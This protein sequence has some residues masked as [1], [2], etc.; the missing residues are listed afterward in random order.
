MFL[1]LTRTACD[2]TVKY[3]SFSDTRKFSIEFNA[4]KKHRFVKVAESFFVPYAEFFIFA[5]FKS[6]LSL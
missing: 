3:N 4:R 1:L 6:F 2:A 5:H